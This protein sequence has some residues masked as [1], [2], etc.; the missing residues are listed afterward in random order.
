MAEIDPN[1]NGA[2]APLEDYDGISPRVNGFLLRRYIGSF[3]ILPCK[4]VQVSLS[5]LDCMI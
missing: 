2:D 4:F 3:V 1:T 5:L